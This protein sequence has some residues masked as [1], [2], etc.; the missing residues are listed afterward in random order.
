MKT[1]FSIEQ[2]GGESTVAARL[3][4]RT[5]RGLKTA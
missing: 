4:V 2:G 5:G 3:E 1:R